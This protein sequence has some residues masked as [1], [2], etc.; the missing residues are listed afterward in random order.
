MQGVIGVVICFGAPWV[1]ENWASCNGQLLPI[2]N[3][4]ALFSILG[5]NYGGDGISMFALPD[6]RGRTAISQ[7][8][9]PG[10]PNYILGETTGV[11]K[12]VLTPG[13]LPRHNHDGPIEL[14]VQANSNDAIT[15]RATN[16]FPARSPD[17]WSNTPSGA[18]AM[19]AMTATVL[20]AGGGLPLPSRSPY[21]VVNYIICLTGL[22]P[23]RD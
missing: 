21:L 4:T 18:M 10:L 2:R 22:Y 13:N 1:P 20:N 19:P 15:K 23:S 17:A 12:T 16:T 5:A 14:S 9:G 8:Q 6:L 11:E 3:N 7:G